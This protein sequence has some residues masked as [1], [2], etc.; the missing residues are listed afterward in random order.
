M[1]KYGLALAAPST[2]TLIP[3]MNASGLMYGFYPIAS[4]VFDGTESSLTLPDCTVPLTTVTVDSGAAVK[5]YMAAVWPLGIANGYAPWASSSLVAPGDGAYRWFSM[6]T[7][8]WFLHFGLGTLATALTIGMSQ[9]VTSPA[10][11]SAPTVT[12]PVAY[13]Y[14][15]SISYAA[16]TGD[17]A[18]FDF[19]WVLAFTQT[20]DQVPLRITPVTSPAGLLAKV[21]GVPTATANGVMYDSIRILRL[22][23]AITPGVYVFTSSITN[24]SGLSSTVTLNLTIA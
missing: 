16:I 12:T 24:L 18:F 13:V 3:A 5:Q 14:N 23:P 11:P 22:N 20:Q 15:G 6:P 10:A 21:I 8:S 9:V 19:N 4:T 17:C 2:Q 1:N 7:E